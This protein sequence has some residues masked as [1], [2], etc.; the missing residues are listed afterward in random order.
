[1]L[2]HLINE[3]GFPPGTLNIVN[4]YGDPTGE[5]I[6]RH[7]GIKKIAFTGSS[8]IGRRIVAASAESNLKKVSLELGGKSAMIICEDANLDEA[9]IA[10]HI[11]LFIN[12]GQCCCA[13]S[14]ILIHESIHDAFVKK[15]VDLAKTLRQG[16]CEAMKVATDVGG[17]KPTAVPILDLGPQIDELQFN[18]IMGYIESGKAEGAKCLLGGKRVGNR[19]YFVAPTI[20]SDVTDDMK[21]CKEE[22]F[23]PVMQ[24]LKFSSNAEAVARANSSIYGLGAGV[25][26][27][28]VGNAIAIANELEAGSVWVNSY[29]NF[30]NACPFGGYKESGWGSDKGEYALKNYTITKC[31]MIPIAMK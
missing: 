26:S 19:G 8:G 16:P 10:C 27:R 11:G 4:G 17:D 13:S 25:C 18:K 6:S 7:M 12:M 31:V 29:D 28:D 15:V 20:F 30:D 21:I 9:A 24:L 14:R 1:M 2:G 3:A 5:L 22:I 23:G